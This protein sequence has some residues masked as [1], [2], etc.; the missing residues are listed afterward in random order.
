MSPGL[1]SPCV[2][3]AFCCLLGCRACCPVLLVLSVGCQVCAPASRGRDR[4][5]PRRRRAV[6]QL[7]GRGEA[8]CRGGGLWVEGT[9]GMCVYSGWCNPAGREVEL[10]LGE[11]HRAGGL[12]TCVSS[13]DRLLSTATESLYTSNSASLGMVLLT[14]CSN[15]V[16]SE[17]GSWEGSRN[18]FAA[19]PPSQSLLSTSIIC[20]VW[21]ARRT[22]PPGAEQNC[23]TMA[24]WQHRNTLILLLLAV[25]SLQ[26]QIAA[27]L[28]AYGRG[29]VCRRG[30]RQLGAQHTRNRLQWLQFKRSTPLAAAC[31][32]S[33][34]PPAH[35]FLTFDTT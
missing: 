15:A 12:T 21:P 35:L 10:E 7:C 29:K 14:F 30:A 13:I 18:L 32:V 2:A 1:L 3:C 27:E 33:L 17:I 28:V 23:S 5:P 24:V 8:G 34:G 20:P 16:G 11:Q 25:A 31:L 22:V 19:G 4:E 6:W 9:M 26:E